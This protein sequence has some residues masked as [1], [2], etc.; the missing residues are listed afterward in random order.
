MVYNKLCVKIFFRLDSGIGCLYKFFDLIM[1]FGFEKESK[2]KIK[3]DDFD[4]IKWWK[5]R[6]LSM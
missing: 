5:R 3:K 4:C 2:K 6:V 1:F